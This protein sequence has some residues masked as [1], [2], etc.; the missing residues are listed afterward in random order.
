MNKL[1]YLLLFFPTFILSQWIQLGSDIN[2]LNP[3]Y[4]EL[5]GSSVSINAAG[6]RIAIG[7]PGPNS[8][9]N[10]LNGYV[11]VYEY[12]GT[13]WV[14][15]GANI[16][17][18]NPGDQFGFSVSMND[19]GDR[20]AI[21]ATKDGTSGTNSG[22]V[23]IF[24][25]D[26][27]NWNQVGIKLNGSNVNNL[28]GHSVSLSSNGNILAVGAPGNYG[29]V[30]IYNLVNNFWFQLGSTL[31]AGNGGTSPC[32]TNES[33]FGNSVALNDD[34][35]KLVV[36]APNTS[37][38]YTFGQCSSYGNYGG[39]VIYFSYGSVWARIDDLNGSGYQG[40]GYGDYLGFSVA[41]N[42]FGDKIAAG[43]PGYTTNT[44]SL[45]G[46]AS[47]FSI[48][49]NSFT[50]NGN[51][52]TGNSNSGEFGHS[53]SLNS[54]GT[55]VVV[56]EPYSNSVGVGAG[57]VRIFS[58][59]NSN[60]QWQIESIHFGENNNDNFGKSVAMN[61]LGTRIVVGI[62]N[63]TIFDSTWQILGHGCVKVFACQPSYGTDVQFGCGSYTWIDGNTYTTNNNTATH[64]ILS[65]SGCDSV[66]TLDLTIHNTSSSS[67]SQTSCDSYTASN[68]Q[69]YTS[70]GN[71]IL[72]LQ[73]VH[74]CD[75]TVNLNLTIN[76]STSSTDTQVACDSY[77]WIDGNTYTVSNN[78]AQ[79]ISTNSAGCNHTTTLNLTINNSTSSTQNISYCGNSYLF[80]GTTYSTSGTYNQILSNNAGC[81]SLLTLNLSLNSNLFNVGFSSNQQVF[82]QPPFF[83]S[84]TN[85]T[86]SIIDYN[87]TWNFGDG[88]IVD[89][90]SQTIN[91]LFAFN[92]LY[93]VTLHAVN[94]NTGCVDSLF[95][96]EYIYCT[97]GQDPPTG[98]DEIE[99][100]EIKLYPN[101]TDDELTIL[102]S[103]YN[104][105]IDYEIKDL[106]GKLVKRGKEKNIKFESLESGMYL[107]NIR[108]KGKE[109]SLKIMK[110]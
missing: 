32:T 65:A 73:T 30:K 28:F 75:S 69:T 7:A 92:G 40:N 110:K 9:W 58:Q 52:L 67:T 15:L 16:Y 29:Y 100:G 41:I 2:G 74:G 83:A 4:N 96:S 93:N 24:D 87:F 85:I 3:N 106:N 8:T 31:Y 70:S 27:T 91:H 51:Q 23:T 108:Y 20:V 12:N 64:S 1:I 97:G 17:S 99:I 102:I 44:N 61:S 46:K 90:N 77:T 105:K 107:M 82:L 49:S 35:T 11:Q 81:D 101:P 34:G 104:G 10:N 86:P 22:S 25:F 57:E 78:S 66:V 53:I 89:S 38:D 60:N 47:L 14:K 79:H 33:G 26:G 45:I 36:G 84:F 71:Y 54:L 80:N 98:L 39:S 62:P 37:I 88:T 109:R 5:L 21:G 42:S 50:G 18:G 43:I 13:S 56:S 68:G 63:K 103:G 95:Q 59:N 72:N 76:N 6:D 48:T 55:K 94:K 19:A